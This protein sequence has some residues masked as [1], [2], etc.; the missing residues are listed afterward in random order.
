[1]T[2]TRLF[3]HSG[4][5]RTTRAAALLLVV[6]ATGVVSGC[7]KTVREGQSPAYLVLRSLEGASGADTGEFSTVLRSDVVTNNSIFEDNGRVTLTLAMRDIGVTTPTSN[8]LVTLNRY[9]VQYRRTDGRNTP[10]EDVPYS[11]EGAIGVTV[12]E[13][14]TEAVFSL[15][16]AQA[17][18]EKPLV[19]LRGANGALVISTIADVTFFGK[20]QTGRDVTV[21]GSISVNFADWA[22]K[23]N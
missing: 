4:R 7:S 23:T 2:L 10:G 8:N 12:T 5:G 3:T 11:V 17:K 19:T 16:R 15:V 20:D 1:M 9:R 6:G 18:L 13:Q 22:D 14:N 21:S